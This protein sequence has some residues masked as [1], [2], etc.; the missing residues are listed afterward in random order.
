MSNALEKKS[1]QQQI[2][3]ET[4]TAKSQPILYCAV[5]SRVELFLTKNLGTC[6]VLV[7][8]FGTPNPKFHFDLLLFHLAQGLTG[9]Q[10]I[11]L[12]TLKSLRKKMFFTF[13]KVAPETKFV[14]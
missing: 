11:L 1:Q 2:I 4:N 7:D 5:C 10:N 14:P 6:Y 9:P 13:L 3:E 8:C 12:A